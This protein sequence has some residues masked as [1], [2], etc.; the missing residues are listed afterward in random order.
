MN[1]SQT[2]DS[3]P[4]VP[5]IYRGGFVPHPVQQSFICGIDDKTEL[6]AFR[7]W[8]LRSAAWLDALP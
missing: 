3:S 5:S 6:K 4:A 1:T 8:Y 2:H 7:R